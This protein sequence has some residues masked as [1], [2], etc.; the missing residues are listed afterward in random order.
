MR[1]EVPN[2]SEADYLNQ[3]KEY[4]YHSILYSSDKVIIAVKV[5]IENPNKVNYVKVAK[6]MRKDLWNKNTKLTFEEI[7]LK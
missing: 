1:E 4:Y 2:T 5:F 6:E 7:L 3:I